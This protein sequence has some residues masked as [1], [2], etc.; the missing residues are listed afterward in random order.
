VSIQKIRCEADEF[1][2]KHADVLTRLTEIRD[3][4][5][6]HLKKQTQGSKI[7]LDELAAVKENLIRL[8]NLVSVMVDRSE[9]S[10][11]HFS[12]VASKIKKIIDR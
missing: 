11:N 8:I 3:N 7:T 9:F 4:A 2:E 12:D 6:A 10:L 1:H 5:I